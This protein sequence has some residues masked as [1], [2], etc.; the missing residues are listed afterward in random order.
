[1]RGEFRNVFFGCSGSRGW[2]KGSF[3][4]WK[5]RLEV[6]VEFRKEMMVNRKK[7]VEE[8][9]KWIRIRILE[10][11]WGKERRKS[12]IVIFVVLNRDYSS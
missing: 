5:F 1:M 12:V 11:M 10:W 3:E 2:R 7:I 6:F 8:W 4:G 9:S